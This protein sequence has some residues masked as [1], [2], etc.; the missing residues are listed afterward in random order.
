[1]RDSESIFFYIAISHGSFLLHTEFAAATS[2]PPSYNTDR[3]LLRLHH[4]SSFRK[5]WTVR[6]ELLFKTLSRP[7]IYVM[8]FTAPSFVSVFLKACEQLICVPA[9]NLLPPPCSYTTERLH[10]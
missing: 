4:N 1:M 8:K 10:F 3:N 9:L 7:Q 6:N 2:Q 5:F